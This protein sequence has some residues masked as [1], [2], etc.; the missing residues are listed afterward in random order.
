MD[1]SVDNPG[2]DK[3]P[4]FLSKTFFENLGLFYKNNSE[5]WFHKVVH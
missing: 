5:K 3:S 1:L 4:C 2:S